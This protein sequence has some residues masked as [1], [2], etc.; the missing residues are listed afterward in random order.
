MDLS[1][2]D[3][4]ALAAEGEG[5]ELEFKRGLPRPERIARTLCAFANTRGGLL[6]V[7]ITDGRQVYG[8]PDPAGVRAALR[9]VA[10]E[11]LEPPLSVHLTTVRVGGQRVVACS[12]PLSPARPHRIPRKGAA[13]EVVV[14]VGSSNRRASGATLRALE[15]PC[16]NGGTSP[17]ERGVLAWLAGRR[18]GTVA[19]F[20]QARNVG[21]QRARRAFVGLERAGRVVAHGRGARRTYEVA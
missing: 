2:D 14:R 19:E 9:A 1:A 10:K 16:S 17:L 8:V 3:V 7:G 12:V 4:L 5:R 18:G 11:R 21:R 6:L 20:S 13:P 15:V